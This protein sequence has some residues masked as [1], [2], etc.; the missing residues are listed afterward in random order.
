MKTLL[1]TLIVSGLLMSG[2]AL[3]CNN[4]I[5][6]PGGSCRNTIETCGFGLDAC[7]SAF[8]TISPFSYF[9]R[10]SKM[11]DCLILQAS[12]YISAR[13]CQSDLCN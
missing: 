11:S 5:P 8:F 1:V 12:P 4:C 6:R 7:V 3:K 9:R 13:C 10:C 2:F